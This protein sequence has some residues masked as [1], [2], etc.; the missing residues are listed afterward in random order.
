[1][2]FSSP[3]LGR[4]GYLRAVNPEPDLSRRSDSGD[5]ASIPIGVQSLRRRNPRK[6]ETTAASVTHTSIRPFGRSKPATRRTREASH[7]DQRNIADKPIPCCAATCFSAAP[8][9]RAPSQGRKA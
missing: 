4:C 8:P 9:H 5:N 1:M 6:A 7:E 3:A 2:T